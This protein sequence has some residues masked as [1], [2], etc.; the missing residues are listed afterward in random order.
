M[1]FRENDKRLLANSSDSAAK[2]K[3]FFLGKA[4]F[5]QN[6]VWPKTDVQLSLIFF[7]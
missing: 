7:S 4:K 1:E 2:F 6:F 5:G 3:V